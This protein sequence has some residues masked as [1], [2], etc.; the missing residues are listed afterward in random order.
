[1]IAYISNI[2]CVC[3][4]FIVQ[5]E[6]EELLGIFE[7]KKLKTLKTISVANQRRE[8]YESGDNLKKVQNPPNPED[9]FSFISPVKKVIDTLLTTDRRNSA[10][11]SICSKQRINYFFDRRNK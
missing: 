10:L 5:N 1:M 2:L 4:Q 6:K 9:F 11:A 8:K 3:I 7:K